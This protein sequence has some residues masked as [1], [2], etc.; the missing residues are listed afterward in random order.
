MG[1]EAREDNSPPEA[2]LC[3]ETLVSH[4]TLRLATC[5]AACQSVLNIAHWY[6]HRGCRG[7]SMCECTHF[8]LTR[9]YL[10]LDKVARHQ[11]IVSP[12]N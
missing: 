6:S 1:V 10:S 3:A 9:E 12:S 7:S 4:L 5:A 2:L 8:S 11:E